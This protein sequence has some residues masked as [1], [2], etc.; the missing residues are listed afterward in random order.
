V[1]PEAL[2]AEDENRHA[3]DLVGVRLGDAGLELVRTV[4]GEEGAIRRDVAAELG[5]QTGDGIGLIDLQLAAEEAA[6]GLQRVRLEESRL[7][8]EQAADQRR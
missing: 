8:R 6:V 3:E 2:T 1:A 5:D 4:A 7:L